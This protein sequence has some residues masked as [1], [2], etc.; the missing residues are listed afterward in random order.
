M[1]GWPVV[2]KCAVACRYGLESQQPTVPQVRHSRR[3]DQTRRPSARH[4]PQPSGVI[5]EGSLGPSRTTCSQPRLTPS[6]LAGVYGLPLIALLVGA[7]GVTAVARR[8]GASPPLVLVLAGLAVSF[9][10]GVPDHQL[11]PDLILLVVLPPLLYSAAL[12]SS[13]L[14]IKANLSAITSLAVGL[15]LFTTFVVGLVAHLLLPELPLAAAFVLGAVVAPPDAVAA[16]AVGRR[17]GLPRRVMTVL[18]GESLFNDATA[19]TAYRVAVAAATGAGMSL[20]EGVAIFLLAAGGGVAIGLV[21]GWGVHRVRLM[22]HDPRME[23]AIGLVVPFGAYL[24]AE[25]RHASGVLAVVV[26]GLYL[27]HRAPE[28]GY[29]TRL[30]D[31]AVWKAADTVLE[32]L[33]FGLIGLQLATVVSDVGGAGGVDGSVVGLAVTGLVLTA[34]AIVIRPAWVFPTAYIRGALF[35]VVRR[36]RREVDRIPW[37]Y[38]AVVSWAGMRGVVSVA[39][40]AALPLGF[41]GRDEVI[42]LSYL[43]TVA[44]L[45]LQGLTLPWVIGLLGIRDTETYADTLAEAQAQHAAAQAGLARLDELLEEIDSEH[46]DRIAQRL[47]G[48]AEHRSFGAWERLG[49]PAEEI[50]EAPTELFRRL[51]RE[52]LAAERETFIRF[53]NEGLIDDEVL[54]SVLRELDLE[55]ALLARP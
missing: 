25:E 10:P 54:R 17:L 42:F 18:R 20:P 44:T 30:Q 46:A 39:A 53:R 8:I 40:A 32:A 31:E 36:R 28:A 21:I 43:V 15:V 19:L 38:P 34:V 3:C 1:T 52:M 45:L 26:A 9:V 41:P 33:V 2:R 16:V 48:W 5:G 4:S 35:P 49:R 55:E 50:G 13:F 7:L 23:S 12:E 11:D 14:S 27:G 22:L 51:W 6:I 29:A 24:I 37:Q 47:R